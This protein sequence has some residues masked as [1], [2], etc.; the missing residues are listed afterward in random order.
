MPFRF[1]NQTTSVIY[2]FLPKSSVRMK[3]CVLEA[4][5]AFVFLMNRRSFL[6][7]A[8]FATGALFL[9]PPVRTKHLILIVNAGGVRKRDYYWDAFLAPNI[10]RLAREGFVFEEDHCECVASHECAFA[11]LLQGR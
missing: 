7:N 4:S 3:T 10:R 2:Y 5:C 1:L 11:E 9:P 8:I 6:N